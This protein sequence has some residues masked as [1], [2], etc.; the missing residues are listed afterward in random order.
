MKHKL[1]LIFDDDNEVIGI[2]KELMFNNVLDAESYLLKSEH[3]KSIKIEVDDKWFT[4][5]TLSWSGN[6]RVYWVVDLS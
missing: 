5:K 1:V 3:I 6:G 2:P 4:F